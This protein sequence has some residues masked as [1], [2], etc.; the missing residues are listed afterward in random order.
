[1]FQIN[2]DN[3]RLRSNGYLIVFHLPTQLNTNKESH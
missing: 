2:V 3:L 1:M